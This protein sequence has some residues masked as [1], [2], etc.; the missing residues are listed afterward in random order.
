MT[1]RLAETCG[2]IYNPN[3]AN[4]GCVLAAGHDGLHYSDYEDDTYVAISAD[5]WWCKTHSDELGPFYCCTREAF[6]DCDP[7]AVYRKES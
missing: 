3:D 2:A 5:W 6:P 7:V 4:S 1:D